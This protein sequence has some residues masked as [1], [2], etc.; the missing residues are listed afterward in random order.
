MESELF[1]A[2]FIEPRI[3]TLSRRVVF[4]LAREKVSEM[5]RP[6][7]HTLLTIYENFQSI[8]PSVAASRPDSLR[9]VKG[10]LK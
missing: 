7:V 3:V 9:E 4:S 5:P 8:R 10:L 2:N 6:T 1:K